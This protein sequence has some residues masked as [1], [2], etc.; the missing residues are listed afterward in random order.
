MIKKFLI[1]PIIL[2]V[3]G[4]SYATTWFSCNG[5]TFCGANHWNYLK[6]SV[7]LESQSA[8]PDGTSGVWQWTLPAGHPGGEGVGNVQP[9]GIPGTKEGWVQFWWKVSPGYAYHPV[10]TKVFMFNPSNVVAM[11][12]KPSIGINLQTQGPNNSNYY[13]NVNTSTWYIQPTGVWHKYKGHYKANSARK[14]DGIYQAWVDD[15][16]VSNYNNVYYWDNGEDISFNQGFVVIWGGMGGT[17][18]SN[19]YIYID[20]VYIGSTDPGT[21]STIN[22]KTPSPP[23]TLKIE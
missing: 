14:Y 7:S 18:P 16:L 5:D 9:I 15:I 8:S 4:N 23:S 20:G 12:L 6:G 19:Q 13:P 22:G 11:C 21:G 10:E 3:A 2:L 17:V 1:V